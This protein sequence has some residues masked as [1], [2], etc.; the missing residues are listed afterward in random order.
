MLM[1]DTVSFQV[2]YDG[3]ALESN[4]MD[5]RE[6]AP[7]LIA[8]ADLLEEANALINNNSAKVKVNVRGS[9]KSGSFG[10]DFSVVYDWIK[11][12]LNSL[13]ADGVNGALN[14]VVILG[15]T[16]TGVKGLIW[17]V[18]QIKS[19]KI[20]QVKELDENRVQF[21][22][23]ED[24]QTEIIE[25]QKNVVKLYRSAK[26]RKAL[27]Q[28]IYEPLSKE[29]ITSFKAIAVDK[30]ESVEVKKAEREYFVAPPAEDE[31]LS[32]LVAEAHLQI[33]SLSFREDNKWRFTRGSGENAFYALI[34]DVEFLKKVERNEIRFSKSDILKVKLRTIENLTDNGLKTEYEVLEV[35]E[36]RIA[37]R[38]LPLPMQ[39]KEGKADDEQK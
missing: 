3:P 33:V 25:V 4:E 13:N 14:L 6:L 9:F 27:E 31:S 17:L 38:Q 34:K 15:L 22:I 16:N 35:L 37:A 24:G 39:N 28:A 11:N 19:R 18:Q 10:I 5:V 21:I 8:I 30:K 20:A 26:I 12:L 7:A 36:H 2:V 29:G 23:E 1:S 32:E